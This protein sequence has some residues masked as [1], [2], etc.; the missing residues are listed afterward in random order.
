MSDDEYKAWQGIQRACDYAAYR[1][2]HWFRA[3]V[4]D[5][6]RELSTRAYQAASKIDARPVKKN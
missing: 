1:K 3:R 5:F 4:A 2:K 6:V